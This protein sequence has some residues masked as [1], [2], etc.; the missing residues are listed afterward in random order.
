[1]YLF[2]T[3]IFLE[4]L[5]DQPQA[6]ACEKA[7][8]TIDANHEGWISSFSL[9][10]IEAIVGARAKQNKLLE[11]FL[12]AF[13]QHPYLFCYAT[14]LQEEIEVVRLSPKWGLDFDDALQCY[15]ASKRN[16]SLVTLDRD[17]KKIKTCGLLSPLEF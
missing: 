5:L 4:I 13:Y 6:G 11:N 9:H 17:F 7:L 15:I 16:L 3:N 2:D 14:T 12:D 8:E 10:A 1:M